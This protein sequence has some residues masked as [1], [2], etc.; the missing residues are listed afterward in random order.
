[1]AKDNFPRCE[2]YTLAF[3]G[4]YVNDP[5]DPGGATNLGVIQANYD[6]YRASKK[7][8]VR[9][10]RFIN[11]AEASEIY[12]TRYWTPLGCEALPPGVDL[13]A[14]DINVNGGH[15]HLWIA[16]TAH[17]PPIARVHRLDELRR[18]YWRSLRIFR[19]FGKGW[20]RR[21]DAALKL[22]LKMAAA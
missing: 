10:V 12:E 14:F 19:F 1:M 17:L 7:L 16:Q 21:E 11:H 3:E 6:R 9:S 15:A 2:A 8:P 5:K 18:G 4:G 20:F 22:A 13:L